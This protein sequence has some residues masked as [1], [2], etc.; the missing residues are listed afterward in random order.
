MNFKNNILKNATKQI[1]KK[2][3]KE[4]NKNSSIDNAVNKIV[5]MATKHI[6]DMFTMDFDS[7]KKKCEL[8]DDTGA[9]KFKSKEF[10][11]DKIEVCGYE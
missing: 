1:V 6:I 2:I 7:L 3:S 5:E 9:L 10:D 8:Y 4:T 11:G